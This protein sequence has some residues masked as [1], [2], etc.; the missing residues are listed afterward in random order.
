[1]FLPQLSDILISILATLSAA[2]AGG[3][4]VALPLLAIVLIQQGQNW[5]QMPVLGTFQ[6]NWVLG[7]LVSWSLFEILASK[8]LLGQR[9]Q[10]SIQLFFSPLAGVILAMTVAT[11]RNLPDW[12]LGILAGVGGMVALVLYLVK[13]GWFYRLRGLPLWLTLGE[14]FLCVALVF[15]AFGAPEQGGLVALVLLWLAIRSSSAWYQWYTANPALDRRDR[16][17]SPRRP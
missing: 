12:L 16:P 9:I 15:M 8:T 5:S 3:M 2:A 13:M 6:P 14:D 17:R 10:Q 7:A 11:N 4:R 1:M